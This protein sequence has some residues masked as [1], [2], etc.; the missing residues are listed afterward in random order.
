MKFRET[1]RDP[2]AN[3]VT[4]ECAGPRW[5]ALFR[6]LKGSV[7][8]LQKFFPLCLPRMCPRLAPSYLGPICALFRGIYARDSCQAAILATPAA[9]I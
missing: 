3:D 4:T 9:C 2:P 6:T 8:C 7:L 1:F 5:R